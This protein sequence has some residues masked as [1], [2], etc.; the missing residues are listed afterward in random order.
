[1]DENHRTVRW[2]Y[3]IDK[4]PGCIEGPQPFDFLAA[5]G[6]LRGGEEQQ[7]VA[8]A[9]NFWPQKERFRLRKCLFARN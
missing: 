9:I 4:V 8:S 3:T 7:N 2:F 1:I 5:A 6:D